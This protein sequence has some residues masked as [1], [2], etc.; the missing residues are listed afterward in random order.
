M[1][2]LLVSLEDVLSL[3]YGTALPAARRDSSGAIPVA[4]SNGKESGFKNPPGVETGTLLPPGSEEPRCWWASSDTVA[5][6]RYNLAAGRYKPQVAEQ[7]PAED[8]A[9]LI[10]E[11]LAL[12]REIVDG[13]DKLLKEVDA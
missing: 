3:E 6:N 8:P 7:A 13:L 1:K 4:G 11:V 10:R 9:E 5:E 2:W 12:E